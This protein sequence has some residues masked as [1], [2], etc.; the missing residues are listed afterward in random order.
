MKTICVITPT[1]SRPTLRKALI[2]AR[3]TPEDEWVVVGD[4]PQPGAEAVVESLAIIPYLHYI[5]GPL[6]RNMGNE[7]RDIGMSLSHKDYFLFM[8]DDDEFVPGAVDIVRRHLREVK[9]P[10]PIIFR[11]HHNEHVIWTS[12]MLEPGNVGTSMFCIP[13]V[14]GR[15]GKWSG[16]PNP[17]TSDLEFLNDTLKYWNAKS[18]LIWSGD[19]IARHSSG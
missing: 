2:S 12:R 8:D 1:I 17:Q 9:G 11:M 19:V 4:G 14:P 6:T 7:Q 13:N 5:E 16:W 10:R 3:L 15:L 18:D